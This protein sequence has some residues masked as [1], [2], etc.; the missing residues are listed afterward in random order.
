MASADTSDPVAARGQLQQGFALKQQGKCNEAIPHF[1]ESFRLDRQPKALLNL[2]DCEEKLG[3]LGA[4]QTHFVEARELAR[5]QGLEPLKALAEQR[6]KSTEERMPKLLVKVGPDAP[7]DTTVTRDGMALGSV[8]LNSPLPIDVGKHVILARGGGFQRQYEVTIAEGETKELVVT[9]VGGQPL[10][11]PA[12]PLPARQPSAPASASSS[13]DSV[14]L[15]VQPESRPSD[16]SSG[17]VQRFSGFSAIGVGVV[18]L[19]VGTVFGLTVSKKRDEID[20]T[21]PTGQPCSPDGVAR[22]HDAVD[23]ARNARTLSLIGFGAGA[24]LVGV[25]A[26]LVLTAPKSH[27]PRTALWLRPAIGSAGAGVAIDGTW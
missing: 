14:V 15:S 2:A 8:S 18:G 10:S 25:G 23:S 7:G 20:A 22:Y 5:A 19:A 9:P 12:S 16:R 21:C 26:A 11:A 3:R 17:S 13:R 27:E 1:E 4:A 24:V 6:L